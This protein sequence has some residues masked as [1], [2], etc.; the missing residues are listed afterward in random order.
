[1][2]ASPL[3]P[4]QISHHRLAR[5][6]L[7]QGEILSGVVQ[8][9]LRIES[10]GT[11][12]PRVIV[13][14]HRFAVVVS[15]DCDLTQDHAKRFPTPLAPEKLIPSVLLCEAFPADELFTVIIDTHG[16]KSKA[17]DRIQQNNDPRYHFLQKAEREQ[18]RLHEGLPELALDFKRYFTIPTAEI[19]R[20]IELNEAQR[21]CVLVSPYLEHLSSRFAYY[22]GR[23]GLP[24][25]H[26]TE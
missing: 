6:A 2:Y 19:Y 15:Q 10:V 3:C 18:D 25:D 21:R 24:T 4:Y 1:M 23:V 12:E 20:R 8:A 11:P 22:L 14:T 9:Y 26:I 5:T 13:R 16:K 7:R 17:W